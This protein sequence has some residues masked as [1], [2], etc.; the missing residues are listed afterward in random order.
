MKQSDAR[1]LKN[2]IYVLHWKSGGASPASVGRL[3]DGSCWFAP[4]N[5]VSVSETGIACTKWQLVAFVEGA[6]DD[7]ILL[8]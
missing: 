5:W 6:C 1:K 3:H 2:G 4:T 8:L 7:Y